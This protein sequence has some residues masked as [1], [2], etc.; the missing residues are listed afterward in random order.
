V[1]A[2][3]LAL[4]TPLW[5]QQE[6][7]ENKTISNVTGSGFVHESKDKS[8]G[9]TGLKQ[10]VVLTRERKDL[11]IK[12]LF[13]TGKFQDVQ[14]KTKPDPADPKNKINV[15]I[16]VVEYIIVE[17]VEFKGINEIPIATL[18]P[19]LR[20]SAGEPLNPFHLK[21][22]RDYIREQYLQ[23]GYHFSSVE[24][25]SKPGTTGVILTWNVVEGPLVTI[26][27]I[28][29]TGNITVDEAELRRFML[30]KENDRLFGVILTSKNPFIERNIR[31]DIDR[32][33]LYYRL[34]GWLDIQHGNNVF[35]E[36]LE[37]NADKTRVTVKIHIIEGERYK[38]RSVHFEFD[39]TSR[40]IFPEA[41]M[42]TWLVSKPGEPFTENNANKDVQKL[43]D[44]YG[45]RAYIQAEINHNEI[46][47]QF[48]RELDLVYS[49]KENDK[50]YVGRILI[51][52]NT[53]TREDVIRRE[54][55]RTGFLP[56]E[57][58]NSANLARAQ[59]RIKD[60]QLLDSQGPGLTIRTQ[61]TDD[62]QTRD[63]IIDVKE[64]QTGTIR[65]AAGYSSSFGITGLLEFTQRNFDI[66]DLPTSWDDL[67]GGTGFAGGGQFLRLRV[68][69]AAKRQSY[70]ADFREPYVFGYEFGMGVRLYDI[71]TL[72]ESYDERRLGAAVTVD[73]RF[74]PFTAQVTL[75]MYQIDIRRVDASAPLAVQE[76]KGTNSVFSLT[77]A[78]ILDTR[79]SFVL[80]TSGY[81]LLISE[82]YAG[83]VL[84][85]SFDYNK[86]SFEAE[87]HLTLAE[88]DNHLK[89]VMSLQF[90]FG[91]GSGVRQTPDVPIFER[92]YAGG[93]D[94][95]RGFNFRGMGPHENGD[96]VGGD[97]LVLGTVEYSYP[98]FVEFLRGA[99]F[100]DIANLTPDIYDLRHEKWRNVVGFG[101]RFFIPQLGNIPVKLDFG[102]P[103]TK[104]REDDRQTVTFDIGTLG[105]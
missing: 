23:K 83:Q 32:I 86:F 65:F 92:F 3:V 61:D 8:I 60:R 56:G 16:E 89:H 29:F 6:D 91:Y 13:K 93:R 95:P 98:I 40:R 7:W 49:I 42:L 94:R 85:G 75:D 57:E 78:L 10:G 37:F 102:F 36:D 26:D 59:Q 22:D 19:N 58:Y 96:P 101:I 24:E 104:R 34:E 41:E 44:K 27:S 88:T 38:I 15:T 21:Q 77:P 17:K 11:A 45:E 9:Y 55:T 50:I 71:N 66:A 81:K 74:D 99:V 43:R 33:K 18:K 72:W 84:P 87:G 100:Y 5:A 35:L 97:A 103:L 28:I 4:A 31:E 47:D 30:S 46:V 64:G 12:E 1:L 70:T 68:A 76:L 48:K 63:V 105:F 62:P 52:G 73:K 39:P 51:E 79:D 67:L 20:L 25:S 90:T 54:F 69:P 2:I 80:P 82:Q 53:K 14:I